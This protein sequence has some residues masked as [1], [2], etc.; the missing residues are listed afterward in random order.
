M[1]MWKRLADY[2]PVM[3]VVIVP[4]TGLLF[5]VTVAAVPCN[6]HRAKGNN[7]P[8]DKDFPAGIF[9]DSRNQAACQASL[10]AD[11]QEVFPPEDPPVYIPGLAWQRECDNQDHENWDHCQVLN[12]DCREKWTCTWDAT[13]SPPCRVFTAQGTYFT[14][15]WAASPSCDPTS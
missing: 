10:G 11:R 7:L 4:L 2:S 6:K 5:A 13:S 9:C 3:L 15:Q 8:C 14:E 1:S 12:G